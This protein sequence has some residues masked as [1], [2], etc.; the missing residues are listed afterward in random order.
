M[1]PYMIHF[2][3]V[4]DFPYNGLM[5]SMLKSSGGSRRS[6]KCAVNESRPPRFPNLLP[7]LRYLVHQIGPSRTPHI[8]RPPRNMAC[9]PRL[10]LPSTLLPPPPLFQHC[11]L[12]AVR[13]FSSSAALHALRAQLLVSLLPMV[14]TFTLPWMATSIIVIVDLLAPAPLSMIQPISFQS[15]KWTKL[16]PTLRNSGSH[17]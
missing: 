13:L 4:S 11:P 1:K 16:V 8:R 3:A 7:S 12:D 14:V 17:H 10:P 6:F 5:Y 2:D 15:I 9:H